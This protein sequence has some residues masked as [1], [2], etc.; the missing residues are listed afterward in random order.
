MKTLYAFLF[1]LICSLTLFAQEKADSITGEATSLRN[2]FSAKVDQ[3]NID[4]LQSLTG[5][6]IFKRI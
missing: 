6:P 2:K 3:V 5:W 1:L 4:S